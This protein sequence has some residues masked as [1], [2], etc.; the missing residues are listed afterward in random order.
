MFVSRDRQKVDTD[1]DA[2]QAMGLHTTILFFDFL[3]VTDL[4]PISR[5]IDKPVLLLASSKSPVTPLQTHRGP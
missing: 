5:H 1:L 2:A 4:Y 3:P